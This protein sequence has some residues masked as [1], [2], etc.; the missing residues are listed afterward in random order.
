MSK[1]S[2]WLLSGVVNVLGNKSIRESGYLGKLKI[3]TL[4][5]Q[6]KN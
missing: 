3:R 1:E 4:L 2:K 5:T 6:V